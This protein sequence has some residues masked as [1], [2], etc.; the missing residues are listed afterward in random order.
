MSNIARQV[1][2]C[3][4]HFLGRATVPELQAG[5]PTDRVGITHWHFSIHKLYIDDKEFDQGI[6]LINEVAL[7][8]FGVIENVCEILSKGKS[9]HYLIPDKI[10][11]AAIGE[12]VARRLWHSWNNDAAPLDEIVRSALSATLFAEQRSFTVSLPVYGLWIDEQVGFREVRYER[13]DRSMKYRELVSKYDPPNNESHESDLAVGQSDGFDVIATLQCDARFVDEAIL[14]AEQVVSRDLAIIFYCAMRDYHGAPHLRVPSLKNESRIPPTFSVVAYDQNERGL[15]RPAGFTIGTETPLHM[16]QWVSSKWYGMLT[17]V[18][19]I[20]K[21]QQSS[22]AAK[23]LDALSWLGR[24][25]SEDE[26]STRLLYQITALEHLLP[27]EGKD[28]KVLQVT[29]LTTMLAGIVGFDKKRAYRMV[30]RAYTVRSEVVHGSRMT[31]SN[32][33]PERIG[34]LLDQIV[35]YL[36]FHDEGMTKLSMRPSDWHGELMSSLF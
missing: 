16:P 9:E 13:P 27:I 12:C 10:V 14:S 33:E 6:G 36:L 26:N 29:M 17:T 30:R 21:E 35:D 2:E 20:S 19:Q 22:V 8:F 1:Q 18:N 3:V 4:E 28:E 31:T 5:F 25:L 11:Q 34:R 7:G 24:S 23:L 32:Y 15:V